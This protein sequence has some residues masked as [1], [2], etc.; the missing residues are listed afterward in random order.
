MGMKMRMRMRRTR[1]KTKM[2]SRI[3]TTYE[4]DSSGGDGDQVVVVSARH[5]ELSR[6]ERLL[7]RYLPWAV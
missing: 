5:M 2:E 7:I 3:G 6:Q 4:N 1:T